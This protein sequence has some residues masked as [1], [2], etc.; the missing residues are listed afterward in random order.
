MRNSQIIST[1]YCK[2]VVSKNEIRITSPWGD[3]DH[4]L[5]AKVFRFWPPVQNRAK[6]RSETRHKMRWKR[7]RSTRKQHPVCSEGTKTTLKVNGRGPSFNTFY[8][9]TI[10]PL[11]LHC[12]SKN[13]R[14][15]EKSQ[16]SWQ[17]L[18]LTKEV[19]RLRR[20]LLILWGLSLIVDSSR[21]PPTCR[22]LPLLTDDGLVVDVFV[23][24]AAP[25]NTSAKQRS[26]SCRENGCAAFSMWIKR[27]N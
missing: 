23:A 16:S 7:S 18:D 22:L 15:Q 26:S 4:V 5:A 13:D 25:A 8:K 12:T 17:L 20:E 9:N 1:N 2:N 3:G 6:K 27:S 10:P 19:L 21:K 11:R 24:G 14:G